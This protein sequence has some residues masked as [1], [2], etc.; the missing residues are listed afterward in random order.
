VGPRARQ[1]GVAL[2]VRCPPGPVSSQADPGQLENVLVNLCIN[3]LDAMPGGGRLGVELTAPGGAGVRLAVTDTGG[4]IPPE[5]DGR[6]FTPFAS[7]KPTGTGLGLSISQRIVEEH[8]GRLRGG[9]CPERGACFV[10][11]LP[12]STAAAS[13]ASLR[14]PGGKGPECA[15]DERMPFPG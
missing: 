2:D 11:T 13:P 4:G 6:L 9:N 12:A 14:E 3:A 8:G 7:T 15:G 1:Q 5:M 10:I